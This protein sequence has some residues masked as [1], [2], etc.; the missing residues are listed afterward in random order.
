MAP[1]ALDAEKGSRKKVL[2]VG[3]TCLDIVTEVD[4]YPAEDTDARSK[5]LSWRRGGNATNNCT[6]LAQLDTECEY[7]G[8]LSALPDDMGHIFVTQDM[9]RLGIGYSNCVLHPHP[10]PSSMVV[11]N[12]ASGSR[13]IVHYRGQIPEITLEDFKKVD[14]SEYSWI[15]FEG[16]SKTGER[17]HVSPIIKYVIAERDRLG[18]DLKVS[19]ELEKTY[20]GVEKTRYMADVVFVSKEFSAMI[21]QDSPEGMVK[22]FR[23]YIRND[24]ILI[25]P[26]GAKGAVASTETQIF[27]SPSYPPKNLI[28]TLGAGDSFV[29]STISQLNKGIPVAEAISFGCRFAGA[30]CGQMGLENVQF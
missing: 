4:D 12:T 11:L 17:P 8:T 26:W 15:H 28:D 20:N 27:K 16:Q 19:V 18:L 5:G 3:L 22:E 13:T 21:G 1:A 29:G 30:K 6:V 25:C 9:A 14:L 23:K 7:Y 10:V 2:C 24:A